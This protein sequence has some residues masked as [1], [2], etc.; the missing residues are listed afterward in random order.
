MGFSRVSS[1]E[2][3][4][5]RTCSLIDASGFTVTVMTHASTASEPFDETRVGLDHLAFAVADR[6]TLDAWVAHLDAL[7]VTHSG[8][9]EAHFGDTVVLRDPDD[10][11]LELFVFNPSG[12]DL[13]D[14]LETDPHRPR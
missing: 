13:G 10:I 4:A 3:A 1:T 11:Q 8:V 9:I 7:G 2:H 14:L 6:P 12:A 5:W